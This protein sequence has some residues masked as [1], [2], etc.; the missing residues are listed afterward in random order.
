MAWFSM[1]PILF[2]VSVI[3]LIVIRRDLTTIFYLLGFCLTELINF[4]LKNLIKQPRPSLRTS[5]G[6]FSKHGKIL[7]YFII[8]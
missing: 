4:I 6:S 2:V 1:L 7:Y 3:T 5:I 8:I